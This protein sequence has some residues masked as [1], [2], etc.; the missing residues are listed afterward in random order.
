MTI[1]G[2]WLRPKGRIIGAFVL[3]A[4]GWFAIV[5][6]LT[7]TSAPGKSIAIIG[8]PAQAL[9]AVAR[10]NGHTRLL[11]LRHHRSIRRFRFRRPAL[12]RRRA[13]GAGCRSG[14]RLQWPAAE[15]YRKPLIGLVAGRFYEAYF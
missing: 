9:A 1:D 7:F 6:A 8:P 5:V 12:C 14:R 2:R 4:C 13:A 10:A 15:A 11:R 3:V